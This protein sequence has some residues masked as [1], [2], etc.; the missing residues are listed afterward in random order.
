MKALILTISLLGF[1]LGCQTSAPSAADT[2]QVSLQEPIVI[3]LAAGG[4]T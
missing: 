2:V 3:T 1:A 4:V